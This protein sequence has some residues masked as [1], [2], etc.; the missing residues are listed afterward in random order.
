MEEENTMANINKT[1]MPTP[2]TARQD[3]QYTNN[4]EYKINNLKYKHINASKN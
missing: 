2:K 4:Y 1:L 3:G